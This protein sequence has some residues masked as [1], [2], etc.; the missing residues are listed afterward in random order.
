MANNV[1]GTKLP[2]RYLVAFWQSV[3]QL[4]MLFWDVTMTFNKI[5][6]LLVKEYRNKAKNSRCS[7]LSRIIKVLLS[8]DV[9][10]TLNENLLETLT[11]FHVQNWGV[12]I[13]GDRRLLPF[14]F[15]FRTK[16]G[17]TVSVS[18]IRC[19]V[20]TGVQKL[21]GPEISRFCCVYYNF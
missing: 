12:A 10:K 21:Y 11:L 3:I 8:H 14:H 13:G 19:I 17:P 15:N 16:Q 7:F 5:F 1:I 4:K 20:F 6:A 9:V 18:N 2:F